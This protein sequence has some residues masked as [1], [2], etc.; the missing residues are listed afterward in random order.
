MPI[1]VAVLLRRRAAAVA[2]VAV[3]ALLAAAVLPRGFGGGEASGEQS[4]PQLRVLT[5]NLRLGR[6]APDTVVEL[7]GELR[8]DVL[9]V[10]ELT[11]GLAAELR[12]L[13][14]D[15]ELPHAVLRTAPGSI[16]GGIYARHPLA[17]LAP[18][19]PSVGGAYIPRARLRVPGAGPIEVT[20]VHARPPT[21]PAATSD[22]RAGL[23]SLPAAGRG[24][25]R[26]LL[27]DFNATLDH[28]EL[29]D[30]IARGYADAADDAGKGLVPTWPEGRLFPPPVTIDHLLVDERIEVG[31]VSVHELPGSDHRAVFGELAL[32]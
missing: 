26:L 20:A 21:G 4:G 14:L 17:D 7:V 2:A 31:E 15:R 18:R 29:R 12:R 3:T 28:A 13:G 5:A 11:P 24:P 16:G 19:A 25:L 8:V 9:S 6:A 10:Q 32:P 27:G 1:A 23:E 22:W 30:V